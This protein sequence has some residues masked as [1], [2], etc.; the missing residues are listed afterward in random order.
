MQD[1][2][3]YK[4]RTPWLDR[5]RKSSIVRITLKNMR[6]SKKLQVSAT[7]QLN[8]KKKKRNSELADKVFEMNGLSN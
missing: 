5:T 6:T 3:E 4:R 2:E 8:N 7:E 1:S